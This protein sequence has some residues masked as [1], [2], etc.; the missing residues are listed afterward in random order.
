[1]TSTQKKTSDISIIVPTLNEADNLPQLQA[2]A[3]KVR[4]LIVVDGG[5]TDGTV[6]IAQ[7]LGFTVFKETGCE[8]RGKQLNTGA[9]KA[10][11]QIVLFLHADTLLPPDFPEAVL[12]CLQNN[13]NSLGAF[14]LKINTN[15]ILLKFIVM[16]ANLRSRILNLPYGDQALFMRRADFIKYGGFQEVPIMEDFM[17][18]KEAGRHGKI[19]TLPQTVTTSARRWQRLGTVRTTCINQIVIL[20]YYLGVPPEKLASFYRRQ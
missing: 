13:A 9:L 5:S 19:Q 17:L 3:T 2:A 6:E 7:E 12:K 20:G 10:S 4:E 18:I 15:K 16:F 1:M 14:S 11:S 8:G